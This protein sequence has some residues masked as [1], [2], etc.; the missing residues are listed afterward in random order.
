MT[1]MCRKLYVIAA[2]EA[3]EYDAD[4]TFDEVADWDYT[5]ICI[6]DAESNKALYHN[7]TVHGNP[8]AILDGIMVGIKTCGQEVA[9]VP[10]VVFVAEGAHPSDTE[11]VREALAKYKAQRE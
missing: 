10:I 6:I 3:D 9:L 2:L 8:G 5:E 1:K 7:D 4:L 11:A